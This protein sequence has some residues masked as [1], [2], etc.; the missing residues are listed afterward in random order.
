MKNG[1]R[2]NWQLPPED[3]SRSRPL[4]R[5]YQPDLVGD[6]STAPPSDNQQTTDAGI[7]IGQ[8]EQLP[9]RSQTYWSHKQHR[10]PKG[11]W[12]VSTADRE[13]ALLNF[14]SFS[15]AYSAAV[16]PRLERFGDERGFIAFARRVGN[17]FV[18]GD[19][20]VSPENKRKLLQEFLLKFPKPTFI[21]VHYETAMLLEQQGFFVNEMGVDTRLDLD[22]FHF[23][24]RT[25]EWLRYAENWV[26]RRGY[27][28]REFDI[29]KNL[30]GVERVSESWRATRTVRRKEVR[31]LNR[32]IVMQHEP[33]VRRFGLFD[34]AGQL[35]AYIFFDPLFEGGRVTG[36]VTCIKRRSPSCNA[37]AEAAIMKRSIEIFQ[38]EKV[39]DLWLGL[40]PFAQIENN[41]FHQDQLMHFVS[42]YCY[43]ADWFN[44]FL[45]NFKGHTEYK[46]RF[47]GE[48]HKVYLA[49]KSRFNPIRMLTLAS[50][51][52]VF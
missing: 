48:E 32:P 15:L 30:D 35:E 12:Q 14:G 34:A 44:R 16:Q 51:C 13:R 19:P 20:L 10:E 36:F 46:R 31:F 3:D 22:S 6:T 38:A 9:S 21:Q 17:A 47:Q 28:I 39:L 11:A 2:P 45:Y 4:L 27:T 42:R 41:K 8:I 23:N 25:R 40:S 24:G 7:V 1:L 49:S 29:S 5:V 43:R 52:G 33:G 50:L 18:L 37:Y 26:S